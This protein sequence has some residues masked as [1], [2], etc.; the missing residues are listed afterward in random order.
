M[1]NTLDESAIEPFL[2]E[3]TVYESQNVLAPLRGR[4]KIMDYLRS[5][6]R[7]SRNS[8]PAATVFAELGSAEGRPCLFMAQ[9][10]NA[11]PKTVVS[12]SVEGG[13]LA[14]IDLC[15]VEH[16]PRQ[17]ERLG[18]Y[19]LFRVG[20]LLQLSASDPTLNPATA[21]LKNGQ[22]RTMP[23]GRTASPKETCIPERQKQMTNGTLWDDGGEHPQLPFERSY[24]VVP[25]CLMAGVY[26][27]APGREQA[28]QKLSSLLSCSVRAMVNLM[29]PDEVDYQNRP[30]N[31]YQ[32][33]IKALADQR[34]TTVSLFRFPIK[35]LGIPSRSAMVG[36]LDTIDKCIHLGL[37]TYVHCWGG[38]GRTGTVVGCYL[39]RHGLADSDN[40]LARIVALRMRGEKMI[41][42]SPET[43]PQRQ[44]VLEWKKGE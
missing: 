34:D 4:V 11:A 2:S 22:G 8:L 41:G 5:K 7:I 43:Q 42:D 38:R 14:R 35:D 18:V 31:P 13:R 16:H 15:S 37:S 30:F 40:V 21:F 25:G 10:D 26:P 17:T 19:P 6:M 12:V 20:S 28:R 3:D 24:W 36:I 44:M 29:E 23:G 33:T 9:R 32:A 1:W 39:I 27:G